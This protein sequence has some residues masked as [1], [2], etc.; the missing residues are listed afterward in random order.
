MNNEL[1]AKNNELEKVVEKLKEKN[2][3]GIN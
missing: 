3:Q 1:A 2:N